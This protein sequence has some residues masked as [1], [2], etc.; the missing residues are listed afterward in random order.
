MKKSLAYEIY[1]NKNFVI[2]YS[3]NLKNILSDAFYERPAT[4]SLLP[5]VNNKK[6]LDAGCG[7]GIYTEWL[8]NE[9]AEVT[10]IDFSNE[11]IKLVKQKFG[12]K[13]DAYTAD[14]NEPLNFT[15]DKKFDIIICTMVLLHIEDWNPVFKEFHRVL[16]DD[17]ILVFS[18]VHPFADFFDYTD[19]NYFDIELLKEEWP[20][21]N[22][23]MPGYRRPL[24]EI[25]S[26]IKNSGF[27]CFELIE[28]RPEK[29]A[30][31]E[32]ESNIPWFIGMKLKKM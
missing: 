19:G 6:V 8:L 5:E 17:G 23:I 11:M 31:N 12:N 29:K 26:V 13:I 22:I 4:I 3:K 27:F 24:S 30:K 32:F 21:Y 14:L 10:V 28:P 2:E 9:G 7:P 25:F 20:E 1:N 15:G 16:K 18:T